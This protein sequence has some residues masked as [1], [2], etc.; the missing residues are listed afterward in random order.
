MAFEGELPAVRASL[1]PMRVQVVPNRF[2]RAAV[3]DGDVKVQDRLALLFGYASVGAGV[4]VASAMIAAAVHP[5]LVPVI[6]IASMAGAILLARKA[7]RHLHWAAVVLVVLMHLSAMAAT[8]GVFLPEVSAQLLPLAG[9]FTGVLVVL[10]LGF[11]RWFTT[12]MNIALQAL[13]LSAPFGA[14]MVASFFNRVA[15]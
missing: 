7:S 13:L 15:F 14:A 6:A 2:S 9:V 10:A 8:A 5:A 11:G 12:V 3:L 4:G 1:L